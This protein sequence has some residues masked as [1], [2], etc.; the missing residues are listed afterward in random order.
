DLLK[1]IPSLA[2]FMIP[3]GSIILPFLLKILPEEIL[4][5][6]SFINK[7]NEK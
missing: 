7:K 5:P 3:G 6:S 1:T 4:M 2:I